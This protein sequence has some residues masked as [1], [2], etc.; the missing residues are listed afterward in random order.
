M[1][2]SIQKLPTDI[3]EIIQD[4]VCFKPKTTTEL[5]KAAL[6][7]LKDKVRASKRYGNISIWNTS[8]ITSMENTF[9]NWLSDKFNEDLSYWDVS[10]VTTMERMFYRC[11]NFNR[12]LNNWDVSKVQCMRQMFEDFVEIS[13]K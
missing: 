5:N 4:F 6:D 13:K 11:I 9:C 7:W 2:Y 1:E 12:P 8:L 3:I 10:N